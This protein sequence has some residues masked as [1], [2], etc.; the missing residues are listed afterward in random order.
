MQ[1]RDLMNINILSVNIDLVTYF[2]IQCWESPQNSVT[3][4]IYYNCQANVPCTTPV[5]G[6]SDWTVESDTNINCTRF[7]FKSINTY[8]NT[9]ILIVFYNVVECL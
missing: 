1:I 6:E 9:F 3:S 4:Y 7:L 8:V 5:D 2:Y